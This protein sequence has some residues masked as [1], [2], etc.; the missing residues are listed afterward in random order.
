MIDIPSPTFRVDFSF[1]GIW[2]AG[3][4]GLMVDGVT[5]VLEGG[6]VVLVVNVVF[7]SCGGSVAS[8]KFGGRSEG[9][10]VAMVSLEFWLLLFCGKFIAFRAVGL[11]LLNVRAKSVYIL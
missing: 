1:I 7:L 6:C 3:R 4:V 9:V 5:G 2:Q 8:S 11:E 10:S